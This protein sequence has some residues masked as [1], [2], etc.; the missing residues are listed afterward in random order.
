MAEYW[1]I[2][3]PYSLYDYGKEAAAREVGMAALELTKRGFTVFSPIA[4]SHALCLT[5]SR[6]QDD[7]FFW[8]QQDRPFLEAAMGLIVVKMV[9]W[10]ES[11]GVDH[12]INR[13]REMKKPIMFL[14]WNDE[15]RA[16]FNESGFADIRDA[17]RSA[18]RQEGKLSNDSGTVVPLIGDKGDANAGGTLY[19]PA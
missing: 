7:G 1:Y 6:L 19:G 11:I 8:E 4:H 18:W 16:D 17:Q 5:D 12:E 9:G 10:S 2:A 3:S 13:S 14:E 15:S